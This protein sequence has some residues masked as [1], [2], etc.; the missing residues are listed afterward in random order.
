MQTVEAQPSPVD[1]MRLSVTSRKPEP[2]SS[3]L[4]SAASGEI[5]TSVKKGKPNENRLQP[6]CLKWL[7][8][9]VVE[10]KWR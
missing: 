2:P 8:S 10:N 1:D 7:E 3:V 6:E 5:F 4:C 9:W